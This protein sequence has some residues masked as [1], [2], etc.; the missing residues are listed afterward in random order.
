ME[1]DCLKAEFNAFYR[2]YMGLEN[3]AE[4]DGCLICRSTYRNEPLNKR[5]YY[6]VIV[7]DCDGSRV[8]SCPPDL[9]DECVRKLCAAAGGKDLEEAGRALG[10]PD[11][12]LG[13]FMYR[14]VLEGGGELK[15]GGESFGGGK[16]HMEFLYLP[17][18]KKFLAVSGE[19]LAGY[20]KI[21]DVY[22]AFGNIVVWVDEKYRR[23]GIAAEL[24]TRT[25]LQCGQDGIIPMY[26]VRDSNIPSVSL[27]KKLGFH[28][29]QR[30]Y[31]ISEERD[32][33]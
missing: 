25:I 7:T 33:A 1:R 5:Y 29:V 8:V 26:V 12:F 18:I 9:G 23:Q 28:I 30:E 31:V 4:T 10:T 11:G 2:D 32:P 15:C 24:V 13:G 16:R 27:A 14:M 3:G 20:C 21:S 22:G 6:R 17:E 19:E